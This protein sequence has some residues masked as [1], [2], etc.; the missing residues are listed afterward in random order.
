M[1]NDL[2]TPEPS[3]D[4][5]FQDYLDSLP[6]PAEVLGPQAGWPRLDDGFDVDLPSALPAVAPT[7]TLH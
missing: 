4:T 6:T 1:R 7:P 2:N 5:L 3:D